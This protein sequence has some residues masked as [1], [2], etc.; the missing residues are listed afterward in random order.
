MPE[1][2]D[3]CVADL[4]EQG[5]DEDAA[6]AICTDAIENGDT[7]ARKAAAP[8]TE[9]V[10]DPPTVTQKA[11]ASSVSAYGSDIST[12]AEANALPTATSDRAHFDPEAAADEIIAA[13]DLPDD[14]DADTVREALTADDFVTVGIASIQ[15]YDVDAQRITMDALQAARDRYLNS[16]DAPGVISRGHDDVIVGRPVEEYT[17]SDD[18]TIAVNGETYEF[19][20]GD[21]VTT[22][23]KA[24]AD[25]DGLPELWLVSRLANDSAL[26]LQT[27]FEALVGDLNGF[28]VTVGPRDGAATKAGTDI[29]AVDW[30][31]TTVGTDEQIKNKGSEFDVAEFKLQDLPRTAIDAVRR[32]AVTETMSNDTTDEKTGLVAR[33]LR[34]SA[35]DLEADADADDSEATAEQK[36]DEADA[37]ADADEQPAEQKGDYEDNEPPEDDADEDDHEVDDAEQ[38][39]D[40]LMAAV[41]DG[42]VS[43]AE[44]TR[45][46]EVATK[47][48]MDIGAL[49]DAISEN[50]LDVENAVDLI[51]A[52]QPNG[53]GMDAEKDAAGELKAAADGADGT[54]DAEPEQKSDDADETTDQDMTTD[55][56]TEIVEAKL[57]A[58]LDGVVT[59][60]D[61]DERLD[62]V[63][64]KADIDDLA[65]DISQNL[66]DEVSET[67][68][69]ASTSTTPTPMGGGTASGSRTLGDIVTGQED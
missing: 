31:A 28:S 18:A 33:I 47:M 56:I 66:T 69:K 27:R 29:T 24:D 37:D 25:D 57:D 63:A 48:D 60:S 49:V 11:A 16:E 7:T 68:Q 30:Y 67:L 41:E 65:D 38:M 26:A 14:L 43:A 62:D 9:T 15:Q 6:Y 54:D 22:G 23:V 4:Q 39:A 19:A 55:E 51:D 2:I 44:A 52:M 42:V 45:L 20:A 10:G 34:K 46:G 64:T 58:R 13:A 59:E 5:Y 12:R 36:A 61:L 50:D 1:K 32:R 8:H 53:G 35:D 3:R 21:T 40:P 17:F